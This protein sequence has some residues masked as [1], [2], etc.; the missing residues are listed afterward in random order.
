M[1]FHQTTAR[2]AALLAP[3]IQPLPSFD[4]Y[5]LEKKAQRAG[6]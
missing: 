6:A 5:V 3:L 2:A 1:L 4:E